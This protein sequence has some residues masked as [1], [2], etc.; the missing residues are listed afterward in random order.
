MKVLH[1]IDSAGLYGAERMLL[2]LVAEQL[3][4]GLEPVILSAG[5][6]NVQP[7]QIETEARKLG[8]PL[9]VWRMEPGLNYSETR[10][11]CAWA[12]EWGVEVIHSHGYKF[13]ILMGLFRHFSR[14]VPVITTLHGYVHAPRFSRMWVYEWLDRLSMCRMNRVVLVGE[15]MKRELPSRVTNSPKVSTIHNG[16]SVEDVMLRSQEAIPSHLLSFFESHDLTILSVGRLSREK[17][18][19]H[20]ISAFSEIREK[21]PKA[22]LVIA[23]EGALRQELEEHLNRYGLAEHVLMPGYCEN[24]PALMNKS[25]L[26]VI[27]SLTEGLPI[28]LL[29]AMAVR[30]PVVATSV[31]EIPYVLNE[32][33][34][35]VLV[36]KGSTAELVAAIQKMLDEPDASHRRSEDGFQML[37]DKLSASAMADQ[38]R[39]VYEEALI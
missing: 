21:F 4:Q 12:E 25:S 32:G 37:C 28:T 14:P 10:K 24:I 9:K 16:L 3:K 18:F 30:L 7:K 26:L 5:E 29:E 15:A 36:N 27:S 20:L 1:L 2:T 22:G 6:P 23:G 11:I 8:L 17:G 31:G 38:Y 33:A 39:K 34:N 19:N 35:G 13:N